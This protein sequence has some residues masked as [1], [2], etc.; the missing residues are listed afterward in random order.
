[1]RDA[2]VAADAR[3]RA[4]PARG[5]AGSHRRADRGDRG[6][7]RAALRRP[8]HRDLRRLGRALY[9]R[10]HRLSHACTASRRASRARAPKSRTPSRTGAARAPRSVLEQ[11]AR[12]VTGWNASAVEFFQ[13]ARHD[14]VHEPHARARLHAAPDLRR[15]EPLRRRWARAFDRVPRTIDVRRIAQRPRPAQHSERRRCSCGAAMPYRRARARRPCASTP[16]AGASARWA[17]PAARTRGRAPRTTSRISRRRSTCR[18]RSAGAC[19]ARCAP[20]GLL[21]HG[22]RLR[23]RACACTSVR[24]SR[25]RAIRVADVCVCD[26]ADDGAAWAHVPPTACTPSIRVLGPHRLAAGPARR[27]SASRVD[28]HY[29]FSADLGGGEYERAGV[30]RGP[31]ATA[32]TARAAGSRD[33]PGRARCARRRGRGRDHRQRP[34]RGNAEHRRRGGARVE[35]RAANGHRPT[36][37][38]GG[39]DDARAAR[40]DSEI[41]L[42]GLL[43]AGAALEG[44]RP[45][46]GNAVAR[47]RAASLHAGAGLARSMPDGAPGVAGR[48]AR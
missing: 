4:W 6:G 21:R 12:D 36:L 3:A 15:W 32:P 14:A 41:A 28:Y 29:G 45:T 46:R 27:H 17:R 9:R 43:I 39:H 16:A 44:R 19:H 23:A 42:N 8:V 7:S 33:D 25:C 34:L 2:E 22:H 11:L 20:A 24:P 47:L 26:L 18:G 38:L 40:A 37:I 5:A 30:V 10:P 1:M 48:R 35:L 31:R 13:R